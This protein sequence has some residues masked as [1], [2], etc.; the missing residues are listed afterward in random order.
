V[1]KH[2]PEVETVDAAEIGEPLQGSLKRVAREKSRV[3]VEQDGEVVGVLV[4]PLD[5]ERLKM[6]DR[7][8]ADGWKVIEEIHARNAHM[9]PDEVE[10][11]V[12]EAIAE[13]RAER[14]ARE[15]ASSPT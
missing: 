15:A 1:E 6:L 10:R 7:R 11:D 4:T 9:D 13:M 12:A 3:I 2:E 5:Y 8:I 14:R